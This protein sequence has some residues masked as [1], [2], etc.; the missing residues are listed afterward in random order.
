[1]HSAP[2]VDESD[3]YISLEKLCRHPTLIIWTGMPTVTPLLRVMTLLAKAAEYGYLVSV[4]KKT[5]YCIK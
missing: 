3:Y 5:K 2:E 4:A 1:M